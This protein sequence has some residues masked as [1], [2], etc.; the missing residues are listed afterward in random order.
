MGDVVEDPGD[1]APRPY[2]GPLGGLPDPFGVGHAHASPGTSHDF[3]EGM[4]RLAFLTPAL[5]GGPFYGEADLQGDMLAVAIPT[6]GAVVLDVTTPSEARTIHQ[7]PIPAYAADVKWA[8]GLL[9]VGTQS[10]GQT[11][12]LAYDVSGAAPLLVGHVSTLNGCHMLAVMED[13]VFCAGN[14][15]GVMIYRIHAGTPT[16]FDLIGTYDPR[17][18]VITPLGGTDSLLGPSTHDMT[19]QL[20]PLTGEPVLVVSMWYD[21]VHVLDVQDPAK[22]VLL[23]TWVG[24]GAET[25]EG[26]THTAMLAAVEGRRVMA[27]V[28]EYTSWPGVYF[29]DMTDWERP[30]YLGTWLPKSADEWQGEHAR[31]SSHNFQFVEGRIY[32]AMNH[33][34]VWV[35]DAS[36]LE[37]IARPQALGYY[38][39]QEVT[40]R[41]TSTSIWDVVIRDG[42]IYATDSNG[43]AVIRFGGD[44][45]FDSFA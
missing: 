22:P 14:G 34:G 9:L 44:V 41:P 43:I 7:I 8:E 37:A 30:A 16:T 23:G 33:G 15:S 26:S 13:V 2:L 3:I 29:V 4:Q 28:P 40:A 17:A 1:V 11:G 21:G 25:F 6:F 39:Q 42:V 45:G 35:I 31:F 27:M 20:D 32:L 24:E 18:M 38:I 10:P 19:A 36:T 12:I 5:D